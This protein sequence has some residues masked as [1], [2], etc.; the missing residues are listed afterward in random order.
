MVVVRE[1]GRLQ[2]EACEL[3]GRVESQ[4]C[5]VRTSAWRGNTWPRPDA[6][7]PSPLPS[8]A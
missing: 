1:T 4:D 7:A 6:P 2:E 3:A 8:V 5:P